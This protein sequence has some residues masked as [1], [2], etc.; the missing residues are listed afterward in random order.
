MKKELNEL[1]NKL[2]ESITNDNFIDISYD[3]VE[4]IEERVFYKYIR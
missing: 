4:E 2:E 1:V 3:V